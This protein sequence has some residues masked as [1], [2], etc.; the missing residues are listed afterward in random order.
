MVSIVYD[1][2]DIKQAATGTMVATFS[3]FILKSGS[4]LEIDPTVGIIIGVLWLYLTGSPFLTK[5]TESKTHFLGNIVV[6]TIVASLLTLAFKMS[7]MD[8]LLSYNFFG[9]TAWIAMLLGI[10]AAQYWD[11]NN[12]GSLYDTWYHK[13]R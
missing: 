4:P 1:L 8:V 2:K 13:K 6:A 10:S 5:S 3:I 9:T 7:T 12:I 11:K